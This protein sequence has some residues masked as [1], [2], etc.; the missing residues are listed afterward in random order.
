MAIQ[1]CC[2]TCIFVFEV[3]A[4]NQ[5]RRH[6]KAYSPQYRGLRSSQLRR[7][8]V[9]EDATVRRKLCPPKIGDVFLNWGMRRSPQKSISNP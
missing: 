5:I 9:E 2:R 4:K 8:Q 3:S 1:G 6:K 7:A